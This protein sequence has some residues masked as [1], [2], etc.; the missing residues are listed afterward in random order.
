MSLAHEGSLSDRRR[1]TA[2][3]VLLITHNVQEAVEAYDRAVVLR[4]G[5]KVGQVNTTDVRAR[6]P[7]RV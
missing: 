3:A 2:V 6:D 4:H 7:A 1:S 5:R